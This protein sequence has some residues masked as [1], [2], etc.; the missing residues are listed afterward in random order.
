MSKNIKISGRSLFIDSGLAED[1]AV[2][3]EQALGA[4]LDCQRRASVTLKITCTQNRETRRTEARAVVSAAWPEGEIDQR[5]TKLPSQ[6][7]LQLGGEVPGQT[8]ILDEGQDEPANASG[9]DAAAG[10]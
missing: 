2:L 8:S 1:V 3:L 4:A 5:S 10:E 6:R 9:K 7:L